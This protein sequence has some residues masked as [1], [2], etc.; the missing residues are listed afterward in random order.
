MPTP[1]PE[2]GLQKALDADDTADYLDSSLANSLTTLD[3]LFNNVSGHTHGGVHQGGPI[4]SI[5]ASAIPAG[6]ITSAMIV[7]GTIAAVDL[8][9]GCITTP[10]LAPNIAITTTAPL[11]GQ[12]LWTT[13][14]SNGV[15]GSLAGNLYVRASTTG[16]GVA[17]TGTVVI[18]SA[19]GLDVT[20]QVY[21][22]SGWIAAGTTLSTTLGDITANRG[23]STGY[24]FLG[25]A[26]HHIGW[27]GSL[28]GLPLG[29]TYIGGVLHVDANGANPNS[30]GAFLTFPEAATPKICFYDGGGN[31]S[32]SVGVNSNEMY[33]S[34]PTGATFTVRMNNSAG[35]I[36]FQ[37]GSGGIYVPGSITSNGPVGGTSGL[38]DSGPTP[39]T[40]V[41][42]FA[43]ASQSGN[44]NGAN[45]GI[46]AQAH[47][48]GGGPNNPQQIVRW[49]QVQ[50]D[51]A[52]YWMPLAQ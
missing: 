30:P 20:A 14:G 27:D 49:M 45:S 44:G 46:V 19:G 37:V 31:V 40:S 16:A 10:A 1:T 18:D 48:S 9:A 11:Q 39:N 42:Q 23:N 6:S 41:G 26:N 5:P 28:Y 12:Y 43:L 32:Y 21:C 47:G 51:G 3:S 15:V 24:V 36:V 17:G 52:I 38:L 50:S 34:I 4:S 13:D 33:H 22:T 8:S 2:L 25:D 35:T 29:N 7:D